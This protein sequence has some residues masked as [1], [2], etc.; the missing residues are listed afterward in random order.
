MAAPD[1]TVKSEVKS[2]EQFDAL[3]EKDKADE[4]GKSL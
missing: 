3:K 2:N 4:S 1:S